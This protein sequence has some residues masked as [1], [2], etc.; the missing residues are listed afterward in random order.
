M[1]IV[2]LIF[3]VACVRACSIPGE[4]EQIVGYTILRVGE[5]VS[6]ETPEGSRLKPR[7]QLGTRR[8]SVDS[9]Q[10]T[11]LGPPVC[12]AWDLRTLF[13]MRK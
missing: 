11:D 3:D 9:R 12:R 8:A 6:P 1:E 2:S 4:F 5:R 7:G 13:W 10:W